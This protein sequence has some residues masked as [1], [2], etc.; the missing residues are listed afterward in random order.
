MEPK[1][2]YCS[3]LFWRIFKLWTKL[4]RSYYLFLSNQLLDSLQ[5]MKG[6]VVQATF[7]E[8]STYE[9]HFC[10]VNF[11]R[12]CKLW[13]ALQGHTTWFLC[14]QPSKSLQIVK[15][16]FKVILLGSCVVIY[17]SVFKSWSDISMWSVVFKSVF[18]IKGIDELRAHQ[19][20]N[21]KP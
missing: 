7:E 3:Q 2:C 20:F 12:V 19:P 5:I 17:W 14:S 9:E 8:S 15:G 21:F 10:A 13:R 6:T 11:W 4:S 1:S 18:L 16:T